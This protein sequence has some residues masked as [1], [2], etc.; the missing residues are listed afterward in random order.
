MQ[1]WGIIAGPTGWPA[2]AAMASWGINA[3]RIPL[4]EDCWLGINGV[5][6]R[7]GGPRYQKAIRAYVARLHAARLYVIL[8]LHWNA[9]GRQRATGQQPMADLA[10]APAFWSSVARTFKA[11]PAVLFDL[12]NE[13]LGISW[14]CWRDGCGLPQGWT[15]AGMQR[16]VNAVRSAGARQPIIVSGLDAGNNLSSWL[17]FRPHD[18]AGQLLAGLHAYNFLGCAEVRC[19]NRTVA[20]V[21][22]RV[23]VVATELGEADCSGSFIRKFMTWADSVGISY[24]GWSWNTNGCRAPALISAWDGSPTRYGRSLRAHLRELHQVTS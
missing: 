22:R 24:L 11:D 23:P 6:R 8:D 14:K 17:R 12:Y 4:N 5:A 1:G 3:V 20:P 7:Y 10:H 2:V 16:L 19:W 18:P 21:A 9:P 15:T 13:P